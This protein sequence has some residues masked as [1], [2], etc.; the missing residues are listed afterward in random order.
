MYG[1]TSVMSTILIYHTFFRTV[2]WTGL[3]CVHLNHI[4]HFTDDWLQIFACFFALTS[5]L[6][7]IAFAA[8]SPGI[9]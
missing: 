3:I 6:E 5:F 4:V 8:V 9:T 1:R 2:F 7:Y